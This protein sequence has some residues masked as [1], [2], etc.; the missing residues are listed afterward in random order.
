MFVT[1][2]PSPNESAKD[3]KVYADVKGINV[4]VLNFV[5]ILLPPKIH[6]V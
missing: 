1:G 3:I 4:P 2:V 5:S 6:K